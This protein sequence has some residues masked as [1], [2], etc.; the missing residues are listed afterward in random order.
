M[1]NYTDEISA[2]WRF[3]STRRQHY[4]RWLDDPAYNIAATLNFNA[5]ISVG[6][7][8]Q[9]VSKLFGAV[10]RKLLGSRFNN[11]TDGRVGGVL[12]LEHLQSNIHVHGLLR[13][14]PT[15][16]DRFM[17]MFPSDGRGV[18]SNIWKAGTQFVTAAHD[19]YGFAYY[20]SKEQFASSAPETM[21]FLN[22]FWPNRG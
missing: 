6:N 17:T 19:P 5:P 2:E 15:R 20:L 9:C 13:V 12:V 7:A 10:D 8:K 18:W 16:L 11:Y 14:E 1:G 3:N 4:A 22:D 21:F